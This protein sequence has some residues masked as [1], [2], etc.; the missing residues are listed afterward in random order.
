[1]WDVEHVVGFTLGVVFGPLLAGR[2]P[3]RPEWHFGRRSQRA[4]VAVIIAVSAISGLIEAVYPGTG[5][6]FHSSGPAQNSDGLTLALVIGAVLIL[7]AADS[8]RRGRRVAWV[9]ITTLIVLSLITLLGAEPTSERTA[10]L[11]LTGAQLVLLLATYR[12]FSARSHR[13]SL[14]HAGRRLLVVAAAL[15]VYTAVGFAVL[16]DDF[17]PAAR[18]ADMITEFLYRM[19]FSTSGNIEPATTAAEWFV[20][21]IGAVWLTAILITLVGLLYSSRRPRQ[22][23]DADVRLRALLRQYPSSNI[24]WMLTWKGITV[25]FSEDGG[26]AIGFQVVGS[27]ALC[28]ADPVGPIEQRAAAVHGFDDY[29]FER[30]WIPCRGQRAAPREPRVQGQGLPDGPHG[31]QPGRQAGRDARRHSVGR[32]EAGRHRSAAVH[33]R[34]LAVRQVPPRDGLHPRHAPRGRRPPR[35]GCTSPS[36]PTRPWRG[37]HRGCPS[38]TTAPSW[39]GPSTSCAGATTASGP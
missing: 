14:R 17:V 4:L 22:E 18:P 38:V 35:S 26:T 10:D 15:F 20:D 6:P 9:F 5:G 36:T 3:A 8:L 39:A 19:V 29:C 24:A 11:I 27:V 33:Q 1:L 34:R 2:R 31:D 30:G 23:P 13:K 25:W 16:K 28:L 7:I 32:L 12:A 21:S 37:S